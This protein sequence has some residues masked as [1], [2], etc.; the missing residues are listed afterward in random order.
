MLKILPQWGRYEDTWEVGCR[1]GSSDNE[2]S[3]QSPLVD[4][5]SKVAFR[6]NITRAKHVVLHWIPR[7]RPE[8]SIRTKWI[9]KRSSFRI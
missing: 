8:D 7:N 6:K 3:S 4:G 2:S 1:N 9:L 5:A